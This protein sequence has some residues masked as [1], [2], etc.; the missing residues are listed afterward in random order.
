[1]ETITQEAPIAV[2][3]SAEPGGAQT[4]FTRRET[5]FSLIGLFLAF[6][7][8]SLDGDVVAT[9][10]PRIIGEFHGFDQY[11]WV[12]T[13]YML[14]AT[15]SIPIYGKLSDLFQRKTIFLVSI[16]LFLLG[17]MLS[18]AAQ[19]MDQL[20]LFRA[21]QGLGAGGIM[22][23]AMGMIGLLF[24]PRDRMKVFSAF[25]P[26][27]AVSS[28][29]GP[30]LGGFITENFSWRW[31][32][33]INLPIGGLVLLVL[34]FLMPAFRPAPGKPRIDFVGAALIVVAVVPL[35][36]GLNWAGSTYA[37]LSW[38]TGGLLGG[39]LLLLAVMFLYEARLERNQGEPI[40]MPSFFQNRVFSISLLITVITFAGLF[41]S[42]AFLPLFTQ[43]VLGIA[44]TYSGLVL[45]PMMIALTIASIIAGQLVAKWGRY[46]VIAIIGMA[47]A[48]VGSALMLRLDIH[49]SIIDVIIPMSLLGFGLGGSMTIYSTLVQAALP[50]NIGQ[51][52]A[53]F[54]FF[55]ELAGPVALSGLGSALT[56]GYNAAFRSSLPA[57]VQQNVPAQSLSP[58]RQA[59]HPARPHQRPDFKRDVRQAGARRPR[60][61]DTGAGRCTRW[62]R[63]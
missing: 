56:L 44:P 49:S 61:A 14:T 24:A 25:G 59:R 17:S 54:D 39:G 50:D 52:S 34:I 16:V 27:M 4:V 3:V 6:L 10:M 55:Q 12:T 51:A 9:A 1:M 23:V 57:T 53:S 42:V 60:A 63:R 32:F 48:V 36:L 21:F 19:S 13:A 5:I 11:T 26:I 22:P 47:L 8:A 41:G 58:V 35:M 45:T 46:K 40:I 62:P 38:Q 15:V 37:W 31:V 30:L 33:Y 29:A 20:I 43:G 7:L 18:G 28:I 2:P